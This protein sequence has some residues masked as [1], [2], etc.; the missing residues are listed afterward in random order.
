MYKIPKEFSQ[1]IELDCNR[2]EFIQNYLKEHDIDSAVITIEEHGH[3]YN[4]ILVK[5]PLS[6]YDSTYKIKT[7]IAHYDRVPNTPGANDNSAS[8]YSMLEWAV[9]LNEYGAKGHCH[10]IRLIFSDGEE[11]GEMGV[12][13]Q[14]AYSL[15]SLF[16]K[17]RIINDDIY[18]FDCMGR[19]TIPILTETVLPSRL[20]LDFVQSFRELENKAQRLLRSV[21]G[22]NWYSLPCN[23]S[24]N[25]G[26]IANGIPAVAI[27]L[28]PTNEVADAIRG[29]KPKTWA[30]N[31]SMDDNL[32][33]VEECA[34]EITAK[35]L[36]KL[37]HFQ[38]LQ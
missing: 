37:A 7:V 30:L 36:N 18:V 4:H 10:N 11:L 28:L 1:F 14:G 26:F 15:A 17:L 16:R 3:I 13:S 25:A 8:V 9:R 19:G 29:I 6:H 12:T 34:F 35:I 22:N 38:N 33:S 20:N 32:N 27:T 2:K 23:Y 31:H 21:C 24:D 5:F